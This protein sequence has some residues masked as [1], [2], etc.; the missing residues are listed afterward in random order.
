MNTLETLMAQVG[1]TQYPQ[2]WETIFGAAMD[3]FEKQGCPVAK[4]ELYDRLDQQYG[5]FAKYGKVYRA[6]AQQVAEDEALGRFLTL[7]CLALEDETNKIK[8]IRQLGRLRAPEGKDPLGYEMATGLALCSQLDGAAAHMKALGLPEDIIKQNLLL[9]VNS[10]DTY[11]RRHPGTPGFDLLEW[12]QLYLEGKLF[13]IDRLEVELGGTFEGNACVYV[14]D[15]R[16]QVALAQGII[17]HKS[18][19]ALGAVHYEDPQDSWTA[20]I[21]QTDAGWEGYPYLE[22]G[23]VSKDKRFLSR[24]EWRQLVSKGDP[25][26]RLHIPPLGA[27]TPETVD[28]TLCQIC[29]FVKKW[30]PAHPCNVFTCVSWLMD[31]Q[32]EALLPDSNICAFSRRFHR[33]TI[34]NDGNGVFNFI[35]NQPDMQF[36]LQTLPENTRLEK[37]IKNH[38]L[39]GK[40]IYGM[41]GYFTDQ[42]V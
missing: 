36:E 23:A 8:D 39:K 27:L 38:Y 28:R 3:C 14:N 15:A 13:L 9:A 26:I 34:K 18:G 1:C 33:M 2:R 30:F 17:L 11:L 32:L 29:R 22:N 12:A 5:C 10:V 31:P 4:K 37:A 35:F 40:A 42:I 7:L 21:V 24:K 19:F 6:A 16:E 41:V 25:V 20:D